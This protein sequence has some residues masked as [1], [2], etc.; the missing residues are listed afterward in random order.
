MC[1]L[2]IALVAVMVLIFACVA[3]LVIRLG[4]VR[5]RSVV[6]RVTIAV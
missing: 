1:R 4:L 3:M 6:C 5:L 2:L